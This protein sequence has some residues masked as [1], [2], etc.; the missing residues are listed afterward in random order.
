M[1]VYTKLEA[2]DER[3]LGRMAVSRN[4]G[5]LPVGILVV[6]ALRLGV[7]TRAPAD[8]WNFRWFGGA[9]CCQIAGGKSK[10]NFK[11]APVSLQ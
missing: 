1:A 7:C 10:T 9:G 5:A 6:R 8:V 4:C 3:M 11:Q 2:L